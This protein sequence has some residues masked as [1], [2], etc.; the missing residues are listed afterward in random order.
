M[1]ASVLKPAPNTQKFK[2][3]LFIGTKHNMQ[4]LGVNPFICQATGL[5]TPNYLLTYLPSYET[6]LKQQLKGQKWAVN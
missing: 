4:I 5:K 3:T 6:T 1:T 2:R